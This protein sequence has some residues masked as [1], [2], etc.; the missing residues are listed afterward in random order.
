MVSPS[1]FY[2]ELLRH[3]LKGNYMLK[4]GIAVYERYGLE[5]MVFPSLNF[6]NVAIVKRFY[7]KYSVSEL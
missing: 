7:G 6:E 2:S 1:F 5:V 4:D 3:K